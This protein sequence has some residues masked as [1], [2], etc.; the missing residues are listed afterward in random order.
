LP[1]SPVPRA[2]PVKLT[3]DRDTHRNPSR[4]FSTGC[5][6]LTHAC[7]VNYE[8]HMP[9]GATRST[10]SNRRPCWQ[11]FV[12][13]NSRAPA[14]TKREAMWSFIIGRTPTA[15]DYLEFSAHHGHSILY[16][17][18]NDTSPQS[19]F[20]GFDTFTGLPEDWNN[21]YKR[22]HFDAGARLAK[23]AD[24]H[25]TYVARM[26][27]TRCGSFSRPIGRSLGPYTAT[28]GGKPQIRFSSLPN[29]R[30]NETGD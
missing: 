7:A 13:E 9:Y 10:A 19:H 4:F 2:P 26:F 15:I 25:V 11:T 21:D 14:F 3:A 20:F 16:F 22:G 29:P 18:V 24:P 1:P 5:E 6:A 27:R 12:Q 23:T 8:R 17:A 28:F 30:Y